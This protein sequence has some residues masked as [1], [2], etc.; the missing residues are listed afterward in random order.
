MVVLTDIFDRLRAPRVRVVHA[1]D[2]VEVGHFFLQ[3]S[4]QFSECH[5]E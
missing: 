5:G 3:A 4:E 2:R 1:H